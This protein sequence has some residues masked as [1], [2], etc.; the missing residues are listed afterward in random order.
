MATHGCSHA[1]WRVS[2]EN[3]RRES[4]G[5]TQVHFAGGTR[6]GA[7]YMRGTDRF[8]LAEGPIRARI[9]CEGRT[10]SCWQ[11]DPR[12]TK[13][14]AIRRRAWPDLFHPGD[15]TV[16]VFYIWERTGHR[17]G[18]TSGAARFFRRARGAFSGH[19]L[20]YCLHGHPLPGNY[21]T[22]SMP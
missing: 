19:P 1:V 22:I 12:K 4:R 3:R 7:N 8:M 17:R 18:Q 10:G 16:Y 2:A 11:G 15:G 20:T 6:W 9:I 5:K 14:P 13:I 21:E